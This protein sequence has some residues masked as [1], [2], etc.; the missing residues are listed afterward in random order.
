MYIYVEL[1]IK[2]YSEFFEELI[3]EVVFK[4]VLKKFVWLEICYRR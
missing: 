3:I 2:D 4:I 1:S